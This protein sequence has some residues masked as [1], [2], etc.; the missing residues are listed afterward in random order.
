MVETGWVG[1]PRVRPGAAGAVLVN[2]RVAPGGSGRWGG[3]GGG[4]AGRR[5]VAPGGGGGGAGERGG[6]RVMGFFPRGGEGGAGAGRAA[7]AGP[8]DVVGNREHVGPVEGQHAG[9]G[10]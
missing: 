8:A 7:P 4:G 9:D 5:R 3:D 6:G 10:N 2:A 1:A